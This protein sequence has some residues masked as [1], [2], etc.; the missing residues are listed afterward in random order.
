MHMITDRTYA[1]LPTSR[2]RL[3]PMRTDALGDTPWRRRTSPTIFSASRGDS[4]M[5][6]AWKSH[7][8]PRGEV[9]S[10][11]FVGQNARWSF[12]QSALH[13]RTNMRSD[14]KP[15]T[16]GGNGRFQST[17]QVSISPPLSRRLFFTCTTACDKV[18]LYSNNEKKSGRFPRTKQTNKQTNSAH[19][20]YFDKNCVG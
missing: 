19:P 14:S 7:S 18:R 2:I 16:S 9:L 11:C 10:C 12:I 15:A 13:H 1:D 5:S 17:M 8:T 3:Q 20:Y 4:V 6:A